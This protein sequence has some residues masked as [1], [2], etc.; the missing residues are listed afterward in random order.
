MSLKLVI[1]SRGQG[2][3]LVLTHG[4]AMHCGVFEALADVLS[5]QYRV[6]LVDLPGHGRNRDCTLALD[7]LPLATT[8]VEQFP[9]ASWLGWSLGGLVALQAA[10]AAPDRVRQLVLVSANPC[11]VAHPG[12]PH[13]VEAWVLEQFAADLESN[14]QQTLDRF[15]ALEVTGSRNAGRQLKRLRS[16]LDTMPPPSAAALQKGLDILRSA[17]YSARLGQLSCPVLLFGGANDR[18]VPAAALKAAA[19]GIGNARLKIFPD[20]G[21][22]PFVGNRQAFSRVLEEFLTAVEPVA[23]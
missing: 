6:H 7:P 20:T 4:W 1:D 17:D 11:F 23:V 3:D 12:W 13:G 14:Y 21:H 16:A 9:A 15:L 10:L 19:A 2:P 18:L 8:L 22:A 5:N